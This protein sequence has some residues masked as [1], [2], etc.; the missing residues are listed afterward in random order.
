MKVDSIKAVGMVEASKRAEK[1]GNG[2]SLPRKETGPA[3]TGSHFEM[4]TEDGNEIV[5]RAVDPET[6]FVLAQLPSEE[7]LRVA[8]KLEELK[9][10]GK[11][12]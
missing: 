6:G 1:R 4:V 8:R 3:Q 7:V 10:K 12:G 5:Y 9:E 2:D 11:I